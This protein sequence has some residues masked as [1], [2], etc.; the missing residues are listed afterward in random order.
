L[1]DFRTGSRANDPNEIMRN[2][3]TKLSDREIKAVAAYVSS[4]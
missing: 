2:I 1:N 3:A 4:L